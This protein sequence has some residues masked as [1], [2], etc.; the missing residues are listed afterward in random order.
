M[1]LQS[2]KRN[3][4]YFESALNK[5]EIAEIDVLKVVPYFLQPNV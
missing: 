3:S 4:M 5:A 2:F 1:I